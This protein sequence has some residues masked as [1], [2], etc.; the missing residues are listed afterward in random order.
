[1]HREGYVA[2]LKQIVIGFLEGVCRCFWMNWMNDVG[3]RGVW[4]RIWNGL[5]T[6]LALTMITK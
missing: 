5:Y 1:M 3:Y 4:G 2:L 6:S